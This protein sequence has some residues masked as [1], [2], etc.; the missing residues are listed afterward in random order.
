MCGGVLTADFQIDHITPLHRGG[1]HEIENMQPLHPRCHAIKNSWEQRGGLTM[2]ATVGGAL[3]DNSSPNEPG[4]DCDGL[5]QRPP[6]RSNWKDPC[7]GAFEN[8]AQTISV[9]QSR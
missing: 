2:S 3:G 5:G 6:T 8:P 1:A 9:T 4:L 7:R